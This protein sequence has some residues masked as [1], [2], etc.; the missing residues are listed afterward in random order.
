MMDKTIAST[1]FNESIRV[2]KTFN[3]T[4][5]MWVTDVFSPEITDTFNSDYMEVLTALGI[6]EGDLIQGLEME[7]I[8]Q[9]LVDSNLGGWLAQFATPIPNFA[10]DGSI[11]HTWGVY[12][13]KWLYHDDFETLCG[14]AID[15]KQK[16]V[17]DRQAKATQ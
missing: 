5:M 3:L 17:A 9:Y 14:L 8:A 16:F 2:E 6:E 12:S 1:M 15:W 13:T 4:T 11:S 10:E 7:D